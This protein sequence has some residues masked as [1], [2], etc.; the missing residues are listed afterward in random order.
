M[1]RWVARPSDAGQI[2]AFGPELSTASQGGHLLALAVA[3]GTLIIHLG[4]RPGEAQTAVQVYNNSQE[5]PV[6]SLGL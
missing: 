2:S 4:C 5:G 6:S 1:S 3:L